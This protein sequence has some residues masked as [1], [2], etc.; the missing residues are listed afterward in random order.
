MRTKLGIKVHAWL[1]SQFPERR[2]FLKSDSDTRF[3]RLRPETQLLAFAG[4]TALVAWSIIIALYK[5]PCHRYL[6]FRILSQGNS[7]GIPYSILKKSSY[8]HCRF[9]P[10]IFSFTSFCNSKVQRMGF[11]TSLFEF[12]NK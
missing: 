8:T 10:A 5:I 4:G 7:Y 6:K 11:K 3:V 2:V 1:E 9:D 12:Q